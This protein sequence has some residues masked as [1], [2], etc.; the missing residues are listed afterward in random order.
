MCDR[1]INNI[2]LMHK[3]ALVWSISRNIFQP[4]DY[5]VGPV[6]YGTS[7]NDN[8]KNFLKRS[9]FHS[10]LQNGNSP[11]FLPKTVPLLIVTPS[12]PTPR[13]CPVKDCGNY[14]CRNRFPNQLLKVLSQI[15]NVIPRKTTVS[16]MS[17]LHISYILIIKFNETFIALTIDLEI[18]IN[19]R[20]L[21]DGDTVL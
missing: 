20:A 21:T 16:K 11:T 15:I 10:A 3:I 14:Y 13:D 6:G 19:H 12:N 1:V 2:C 8:K 7:K 4:M 5:A 18:I 9:T 17:W